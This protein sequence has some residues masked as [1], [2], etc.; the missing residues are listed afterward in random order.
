MSEQQPMYDGHEVVFMTH[1]D[2]EGTGQASREAFDAVWS[3]KGW[4]IAKG[5]DAEQ[6]AHDTRLRQVQ[7]TLGIDKLDT[8]R[9]AELEEVAGQL[10]RSVPTGATKAQLVELVQSPVSPED[11]STTTA[12]E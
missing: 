3:D 11:G 7:A 1:P 5:V 6:V 8:A 9:K 12:Q 10:G 2:V 4:T